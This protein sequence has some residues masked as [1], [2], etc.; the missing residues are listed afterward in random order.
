[1]AVKLNSGHYVGIVVLFFVIAFFLLVPFYLGPDDLSGCG[2]KPDN[3]S[4]NTGCHQVDAIVAI[5]GGDTSARAKEAVKLYQNGWASQLVFSGAALDKSGPSNAEAMRKIAINSGV[6]PSAILLE[7]D[8]A[9]T[10]EN[11]ANTRALIE[12]H[13]LRRIILVTSAYHQRRA[14]LEFSDRSAG[15]ALF[16]VNHPVAHDKQ[17]SEY[18]YLTPSG[19]WLV[20]S[21]LV[22]V[23]GFYATGK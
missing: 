17:W 22:K 10:E 21:E 9:N 6:P 18:W 8:S 1:M 4:L 23:I 11:A 14:S 2:S 16:V 15:T 12:K 5:S 13:S 20:V 3:R 19:W 7:E